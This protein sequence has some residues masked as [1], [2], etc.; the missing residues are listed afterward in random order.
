MVKL[1]GAIV[2]HPVCG[3]VVVPNDVAIMSQTVPRCSSSTFYFLLDSLCIVLSVVASC[4]HSHF[5][6]SVLVELI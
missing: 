5:V 1:F 4:S 2:L 3:V 6:S